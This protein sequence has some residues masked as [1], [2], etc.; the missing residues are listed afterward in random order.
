MPTPRSI[1]CMEC[2]H[3]KRVAKTGNE[4]GKGEIFKYECPAFPNGIPADIRSWENPHTSVRKD[5]K[6]RFIFTRKKG[7]E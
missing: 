3:F 1:R 6:G 5:Q 7:N 4:F 2:K